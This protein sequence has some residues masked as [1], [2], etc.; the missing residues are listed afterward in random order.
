MNAA[1][2]SYGL[3]TGG[4]RVAKSHSRA[5]VTILAGL[6]WLLVL[7]TATRLVIADNLASCHQIDVDISLT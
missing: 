5:Y 6:E 2:T 4:A 1:S 3:V 7:S